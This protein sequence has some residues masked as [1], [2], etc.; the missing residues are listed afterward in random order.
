[1]TGTAWL[2]LTIACAECHNHKF[3]PI[4]QRDFFGLYAF[5]NTA[6]EINIDAPLEGETEKYAPAKAAHDAKRR[7][8][9]APAQ[10]EIDSLQAEWERRMIEAADNPATAD[11]TWAR[12]YE[13]LGLVWGQNLGEGQH[14]GIQIIRIP[15]ADRTQDQ[16]DRLL[17][18]FLQNGSLVDEKK[19]AELKLGDVQKQLAELAKALPPLSR[20]PT[21]AESRVRRTTHIHKRGDFRVPGDEVRPDTPAIMPA[22][23][24]G[25]APTRLDLAR[26]LVR[27]DNPLTARVVVNRVWHEL[28]GRGLVVTTDDFGTRGTPST[29]PELLDWLAVEFM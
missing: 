14:E 4:A 29:H 26:W 7:E 8:I 2:G 16:K 25:P 5:F 18:Y 11:A 10:A 24:A 9:L 1:M 17:D 20:A 6:D 3:D 19:F 23:N 28:F 22:L 12:Q 27:R 21:M 13:V 15:V